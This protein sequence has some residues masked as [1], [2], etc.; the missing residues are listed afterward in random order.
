MEILDVWIRGPD[1]APLVRFNEAGECSTGHF[2][3]RDTR[4]L[5]AAVLEEF[6]VDLFPR[7]GCT[8]KP[9]HQRGLIEE[10]LLLLRCM[11]ENILRTHALLIIVQLNL[12][13]TLADTPVR[14]KCAVCVELLEIRDRTQMSRNCH[15][16]DIKRA[17]L[18][19]HVG[20]VP[21]LDR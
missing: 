2:C 12:D 15:G 8:L 18:H 17:G 6:D 7:V 4:H 19:L 20:L 5:E 13:Y 21:A 1:V 3:G 10:A 14:N 11:M 16:T 9:E